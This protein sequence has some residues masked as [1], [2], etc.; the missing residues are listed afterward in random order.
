MAVVKAIADEK[1][2]A[3]AKGRA[4]IA[5]ELAST[6]DDETPSLKAEHALRFKW[7]GWSTNSPS[8][9]SRGTFGGLFA[10]I[11]AFRRL[12]FYFYSTTLIFPLRYEGRFHKA[13]KP[14]RQVGA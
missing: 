14:F 8:E 13:I 9:T 12:P 4:Q 10:P 11:C 5:N 7:K 3:I 6:A 2:A 1:K